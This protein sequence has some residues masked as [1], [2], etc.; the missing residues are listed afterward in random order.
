MVA[1]GSGRPP[2]LSPACPLF[3][4]PCVGTVALTP[5]PRSPAPRATPPGCLSTGGGGG[6]PHDSPPGEGA[7]DAILG[8][9]PLLARRARLAG[10]PR[11]RGRTP[12]PRRRVRRTVTARTPL[13]RRGRPHDPGR[14]SPARTGAAPGPYT[15]EP[16]ASRP[17]PPTTLVRAR[18]PG[19]GPPRRRRLKKGK[20]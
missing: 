18:A 17:G 16:A 13:P 10:P 14:P 5:S 1:A 20:I 3:M 7:G 12:G 9:P 19:S 15:G 6:G 11:T 8:T 2:R 4:S